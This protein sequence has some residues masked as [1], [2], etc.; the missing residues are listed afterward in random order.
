MLE[1]IEA[2]DRLEALVAE[3]AKEAVAEEAVKVEEA[4]KPEEE[5]AAEEGADHKLRFLS[6]SN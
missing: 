4:L 3:V 6:T 2:E 1:T 5:A